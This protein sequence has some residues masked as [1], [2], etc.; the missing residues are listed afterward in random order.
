MAQEGIL[1]MA[2]SSH[3]KIALPEYDARIRTFIPDYEEMLDTAAASLVAAERPLMAVVDLGTGT[4]ALM[5]RVAEVAAHAALIGIDEDEGM[6]TM[7]ADRLAAQAPRLIAE[8]FVR[9]D[10]PRCD[11]ITASFA[12]HHIEQRRTRKAL[13]ARARK[14]LRPGGLLVS[15][16]CHP[17]ANAALAAAGRDAWHAHLASSYGP[18]KAE[19]FLQAWAGEDF[20]VPLDVELALLQSVGFATDV[21]WRKGAFAVI[22]ARAGRGR[23]N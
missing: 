18:R 17:P 22:V 10:L 20:Y 14:A 7:A 9:A 13:Y 11:A 3:L 19:S 16:D 2:V 1:P 6:L 12:L 5:S 23:R 4:G 15:A 21:S 8:D